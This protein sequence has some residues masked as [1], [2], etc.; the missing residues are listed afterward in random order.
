M[1]IGEESVVAF[2]FSEHERQGIILHFFQEETKTF[3]IP[4]IND[5]RWDP[6]YE[7]NVYL[8]NPVNCGLGR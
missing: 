7:F 8:S 5:G 6:T 3:D 4:L 1:Q 2:A